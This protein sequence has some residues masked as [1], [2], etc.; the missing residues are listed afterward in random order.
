MGYLLDRESG[1]R[2]H[3]RVGL[4][5]SVRAV[6]DLDAGAARLAAERK[7]E[8]AQLGRELLVREPGDQHPAIG[9]REVGDRV[10]A[11]T[12]TAP[13]GGGRVRSVDQRGARVATIDR[14][15]LECAPGCDGEDRGLR[16][17]ALAAGHREIGAAGQWID[18]E[19]VDAD[20]VWRGAG[21][22]RQLGVESLELDRSVR[23]GADVPG[24]DGPYRAADRVTDEEDALRSEGQW[25]RPRPGPAL[26]SRRRRRDRRRWPKPPPR[27][28]SRARAARERSAS[29]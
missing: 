10:E 3:R 29:P 22:L 5:T 1:E 13:A 7:V 17:I 8:D 16:L 27:P 19:I 28:R 24:V 23:R 21:E 26:R 11:E 14:E 18:G 20:A 25:S 9:E 12:L 6:E 15:E 4:P 2:A